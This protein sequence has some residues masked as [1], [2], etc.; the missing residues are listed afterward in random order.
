MNINK[1]KGIKDVAKMAGVS[2]TTVSF[3]YNN[4]NRVNENTRRLVLEAAKKLNYIPNFNA[5]GLKGKTNIITL[6]VNFNVNELSHPT[7]AEAIPYISK[8]LIEKGYYL[9]PFFEPKEKEMLYL[10]SIIMNKQICGAIF[11]AS[12]N[13]LTL[14]DLLINNNIPTVVI[15]D[16]EKYSEKVFCID[17]D[18]IRETKNLV[19]KLYK[20]GY[21]NIAYIGGNLEYIVCQQRLKG[22]CDGVIKK[23]IHKP[24]ILGLSENIDKIKLSVNKMLKLNDRPDVII[25]KDDIKG[26]YV[27][28]ELLKNNFIPGKDIG[29]VGIGGI[30]ASTY[31]Y[32][33]L[34]SLGFSIEHI[35][36]LAV[37]N[38]NYM[39][40]NNDILTGQQY[41]KTNFLNRESLKI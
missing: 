30:Q 27:I 16:L 7:I 28:S 35:S 3:V 37:D 9:L 21:K 20:F 29:V 25:C 24:I 23:N 11:M 39:I 36:K 38:L 40:V 32:P 18:N 41:I 12:K 2:I 14:L 13:N 34:S 15:G 17:I 5:S 6:I 10:R 22:Y 31:T 26:L 33:A 19:N 4:P 1:I 8:Y